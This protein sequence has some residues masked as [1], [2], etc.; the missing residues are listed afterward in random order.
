MVKCFDTL[1]RAIITNFHA[2]FSREPI[3]YLATSCVCLHV[4]FT[5][6]R[7]TLIGVS[8]GAECVFSYG[9]CVCH[10]FVC[11]QVHPTAVH[12]CLEVNYWVCYAVHKCKCVRVCVHA[13]VCASCVCVCVCAHAFSP[14]QA[15]SLAYENAEYTNCME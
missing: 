12:V 9:E 8:A 11:G 14:G 4:F 1:T 13:R 15:G 5:T 7:A 2:H 6:G 10:N 3:K